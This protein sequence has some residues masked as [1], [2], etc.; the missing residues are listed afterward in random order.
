MIKTDPLALQS[1]NIIELEDNT[2]Q[3]IISFLI[4]FYQKNNKVLKLAPIQEHNLYSHSYSKY[5]LFTVEK[6]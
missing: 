5:S 6:K 1:Q 3:S 2:K 4:R